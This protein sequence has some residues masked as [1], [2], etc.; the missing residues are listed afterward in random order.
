M[1]CDPEDVIE[2]PFF[3]E[4]GSTDQERNTRIDRESAKPDEELDVSF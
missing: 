3:P 2:A 4:H 1:C